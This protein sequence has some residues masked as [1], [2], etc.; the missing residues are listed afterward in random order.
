[1]SNYQ[2]AI[3]GH[4]EREY[5]WILSRTHK[6]SDDKLEEIFTLLTKQGYDIDKFEMTSQ[7]NN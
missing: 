3:V 2:W 5:G 1:M 7:E 6:L 4:P